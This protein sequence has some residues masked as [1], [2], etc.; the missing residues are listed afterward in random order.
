M[1][2]SG[3]RSQF[4]QDHYFLNHVF[5]SQDTGIFIDIGANRPIENSNSYVFERAGWRGWAFDPLSCFK[6][7]WARERTTPFFCAAISNNACERPFVEFEALQGWEHQLSGFSDCVRAEDL[8]LHQHKIYD[9]ACYP[10]DHFLPDVTHIDLAL[11][12]VEGAELAV[13]EG[14]NLGRI[15]IDWLLI[16]NVSVLGGDQKVR[17]VMAEH[18]YEFR[19]RIAMTDDLYERRGA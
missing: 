18:G 9:V 14:L 16:E 3:C 12:D 13:I 6:E 7:D 5:K 17:A 4:G 10:L 1:R 8:S 15:K 11:I 2:K 19:A